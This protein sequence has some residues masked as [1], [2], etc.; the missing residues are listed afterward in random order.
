MLLVAVWE[1]LGGRDSQRLRSGAG[2][3]RVVSG[4]ADPAPDAVPMPAWKHVP[5]WSALLS[6]AVTAYLIVY[7]TL[8]LPIGSAGGVADDVT[9]AGMW[10]GYAAK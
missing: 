2:A 8:E 10:A 9:T 3:T 6:I 4:E 1:G 5:V 7:A